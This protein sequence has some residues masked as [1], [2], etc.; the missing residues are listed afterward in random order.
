MCVVFFLGYVQKNL[1][2]TDERE[3]GRR[4]GG[5]KRVS[6]VERERVEKR[7]RKMRRGEE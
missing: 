5:K 2:R 6:A 4:M 3:E 1:L 7:E